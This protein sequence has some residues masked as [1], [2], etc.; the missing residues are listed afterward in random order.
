MR[1]AILL[2]P[3]SVVSL[4]AAVHDL[5]LHCMT[6]HIKE[7]AEVDLLY[8]VSARDSAL[9]QDRFSFI[10]QYDVANAPRPDW[11]FVPALMVDDSWEPCR[12]GRLASWLRDEAASGTRIVGVGTGA[13]LLAEAGLFPGGKAVTHSRYAALFQRNFPALQ[14]VAEPGWVEEGAVI[15]SGDLPWQELVLAEIARRWGDAT[16]RDVAETYALQ[17]NHLLHH[18]DGSGGIDAS[19][20]QARAWLAE[21]YT[22]DNL[23]PRCI[24]HFGL[25]R[26]TFNRRF[27]QESGMTP[28]EYV[29]RLRVQASQS[30]LASTRRSIEDIGGHVGYTDMGAFY[31]LFRRHTGV[32]PGQFRRGHTALP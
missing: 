9:L 6:H 5:L 32:S 26:R 8:G 15:C 28:K 30:L 21:H 1:A 27:K 20:A 18:P 14:V 17:W 2:T 4:V 7:G 31:R 16:A 3:G 29:H 11:L 23:I 12:H 25:C 19:M 10:R 24:Q 22:E 13:F